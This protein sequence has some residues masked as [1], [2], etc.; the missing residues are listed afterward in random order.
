MH[1]RRLDK[2][3]FIAAAAWTA[4]VLSS[5][6]WDCKHIR[7]STLNIAKTEARAY[8]NKDQAFR[9]WASSHGGVY[10]EPD[11]RTPPNPYLAHIDDRDVITTG[12]KRLT[13][14]NPAYILRQVV[15]DFSELYGIKGHITSLNPLRPENSPDK[16]EAKVLSTF[17]SKDEEFFEITDSGN[18]RNLR[19][20]RP[21]VTEEQC[22]KCHAIQGYKVGDIRGGV[23][24]SIPMAP[25]ISMEKRQKNLHLYAHVTVWLVGMAGIALASKRI[26]MHTR[27][28]GIAIMEARQKE[29]FSQLILESTAEAIYGVDIHGNCTFCNSSCIEMLGYKSKKELLGKNMHE[30]IH[31]SR[32]DGSHYPQE[33]CSIFRVYRTG[34]GE[35]RDDNVFYRADGSGFQV[36]HWSYPIFEDHKIIGSVVTFLDITKRKKAE[37]ELTKKESRLRAFFEQGLIGMAITSPERT[38]LEVNDRLCRML[39]YD[40]EELIERS[41]EKI[42][43]HEDIASDLEHFESV[44]AGESDGYSKE[45]RYIRKDGQVMY[46][47]VS[48]RLIRDPDGTPNYFVALIQDISEVKRHEKI[49]LASLR[50]KETLLREIHHRV[51]N[52]MAIISSILSLQADN[53]RDTEAIECLRDCRGRIKAMALVHENLY[54]SR[55]LSE[56]NVA[57]YL[58]RL[59][60]NL[61][62]IFG[63]NHDLIEFRTE[64]GDFFMNLD[65]LI[66][67]GLII[68]ELVSNSLKH[69]FTEGRKGEIAVVFM[70][71]GKSAYLLRVSD[72]GCGLPHGLNVI[73]A[74]SLGLKLVGILVGQIEGTLETDISE[75]TSFEIRF[76]EISSFRR[77][78]NGRG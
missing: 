78:K 6:F 30:M 58:D 16:W 14:M 40:K 11:E 12:G 25:L 45:K 47:T 68:N 5:Y 42:T 71:T 60:R 66:P 50:E 62:M 22:L 44:I 53:V 17:R 70:K 21:M 52:N 65:T 19:L 77:E 31:H 61:S 9:L 37:Q 2:Y 23:S 59:M 13:L 39:G 49:I 35:H 74:K 48:V 46:A 8:F 54:Q 72:N 7:Q 32:P 34:I 75:G 27:K 20:M 18:S 76:N 1:T 67:C 73:E 57:E 15:E 38:W 56:I 26:G 69:A 33:E 63:V 55:D 36:E 51:K 43:H 64:V 29:R 41:W 4:V 10:V 24:V 3:S 28:E